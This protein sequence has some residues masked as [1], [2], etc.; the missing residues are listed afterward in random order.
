MLQ[1]LGDE[2]LTLT[3]EEILLKYVPLITPSHILM[4]ASG[5]ANIPSVGFDPMPTII[6]VHGEKK[7]IPCAQTCSNML[8]IYVNKH[9]KENSLAHYVLTALTNGGVF[10]KL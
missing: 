7:N 9:T 8:Y 5:V 6:F 3:E 1:D 10:S 2:G 4:I